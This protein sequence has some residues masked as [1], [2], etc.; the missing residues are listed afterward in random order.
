MDKSYAATISDTIHASGH[1]TEVRNIDIE[2]LEVADYPCVINNRSGFAYVVTGSDKNLTDRKRVFLNKYDSIEDARANKNPTEY[3]IPEYSINKWGENHAFFE[4]QTLY[5]FGDHI[6]EE[7]MDEKTAARRRE[8]VLELGNVL[9]EAIEE[10]HYERV[11]EVVA[12]DGED[13]DNGHY[14]G[15]LYIVIDWEYEDQIASRLE[16]AKEVIREAEED[17]NY[18]NHTTSDRY[19][20]EIMGCDGPC[21]PAGLEWAIPPHATSDEYP[22][23]DRLNGCTVAFDL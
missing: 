1:D 14:V 23:V 16:I 18:F 15:D 3:S 20:F 22:R 11:A 6:G 4:A 9:S 5:Q 2:D 7:E 10:Y 8:I 12:S 13:C 19:Y 21:L 17:E